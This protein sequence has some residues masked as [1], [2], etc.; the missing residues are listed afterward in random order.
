MCVPGQPWKL[1]PTS[2][3][4]FKP[5]SSTASYDSLEPLLSSRSRRSQS[6]VQVLL[7]LESPQ[8][9]LSTSLCWGECHLARICEKQNHTHHLFSL[10]GPPSPQSWVSMVR[11]DLIYRTAVHHLSSHRSLGLN[12]YLS[13]RNIYHG[14]DGTQLFYPAQCEQYTDIFGRPG[15]IY[16]SIYLSVYLSI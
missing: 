9:K 4:H 6:D 10:Y 16:L 5:S 15:T 8:V 1:Y 11:A 13:K 2:R 3:D 12:K 7:W 14:S